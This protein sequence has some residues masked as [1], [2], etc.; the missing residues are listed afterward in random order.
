[1]TTQASREDT[2]EAIL[3]LFLASDDQEYISDLRPRLHGAKFIRGVVL[4]IALSAPFW[5]LVWRLLTCSL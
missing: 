1:M 2:L 5:V 3:P 4:G